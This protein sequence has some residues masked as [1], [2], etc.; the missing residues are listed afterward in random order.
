[1]LEVLPQY[2]SVELGIYV[3]YPTRK[4]VAPKLRR[5]IDFLVDAFR[6]RPWPE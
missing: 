3:L 5:L 6:T 1:L 4:H 2:R